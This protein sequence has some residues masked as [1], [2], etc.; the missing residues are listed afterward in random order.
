[1]RINL[2]LF[3]RLRELPQHKLVH[4]VSMPLG[5]SRP[6][7]PAAM[8][9]LKTSVDVLGAPYA[10]EH[11]SFNRLG[12]AEGDVWTGF[13]LPPRQNDEGVA[14]AAARIDEMRKA[15]GVPAAFETGVNYLRPRSDELTDGE[16]FRAVAEA[17]DCGILLDLHNLLTNERNGRTPLERVLKEIPLDRVWEIHVAGGMEYRGYWLDSHSSHLSD[18]L[19]KIALDVV[20]ACPSLRAIVF[21]IM[22]EYLNESSRSQLEEDVQRLR[23]IWNS[24]SNHRE[25]LLGLG[26]EATITEPGPCTSVTAWEETLGANAIGRA[27]RDGKGIPLSDPALDLYAD[28]TKSMRES[29]I[30]QSLPFTVRLLLA[31]IGP[32]ALSRLMARFLNASPPQ[33]FGAAEAH[34]FIC[35]LRGTDT[36]VRYLRQVLAFEEAV[37]AVASGHGNRTVAFDCNPVLLFEALEQRRDPGL[38]ATQY[39]T[40]EISPH[41]LQV[42]R[43]EP[44]ESGF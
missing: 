5:N 6:H 25:T 43:A 30:Y 29:T 42:R 3:K 10:S 41:S 11:L 13:L 27:A 38:L 33:P 17:A 40:V 7:D 15:L 18:D 8:Q 12:T 35:F 22:E 44:Q 26:R 1:M 24:R 31:T 37:N 20:G 16:F 34:H 28:L 19:F 36:E 9:L 23:S 2:E 14:I 39:F 4:S 32:T 21:E